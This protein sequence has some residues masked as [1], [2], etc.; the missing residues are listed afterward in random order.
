MIRSPPRSDRESRGIGGNVTAGHLVTSD[1]DSRPEKCTGQVSSQWTMDD[2]MDINYQ[3]GNGTDRDRSMGL[4][5]ASRGRI[6]AW[7]LTKSD[8]QD[9]QDAQDS[10]PF[11]RRSHGRQVPPTQTRIGVSEE[12]WRRSCV[13]AASN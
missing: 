13:I 5:H 1:N 2:G 11:S 12:V 3:A 4:M 6:V 8:S 9:I 7:P 10:W